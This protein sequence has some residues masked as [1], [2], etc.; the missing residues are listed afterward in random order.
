MPKALKRAAKRSVKQQKRVAKK[1]AERKARAK[2]NADAKK[3]KA[4]KTDMS[5]VYMRGV[6]R[7]KAEHSSR[8]KLKKRARTGKNARKGL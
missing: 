2:R 3:P 8:K 1:G 4:F 7:A 5:D 6:N